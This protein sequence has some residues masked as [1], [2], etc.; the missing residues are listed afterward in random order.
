MSFTV[1]AYDSGARVRLR[2]FLLDRHT[3]NLQARKPHREPLRR[4]LVAAIFLQSS[5]P[6]IRQHACLRVV[7]SIGRGAGTAH[8]LRSELRS[9][10]CDAYQSRGT[11]H[12]GRIGESGAVRIWRADF[13]G[14]DEF[15]FGNEFQR[16]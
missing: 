7:P 4:Q 13:A 14:T 6:S 12:G 16:G 8:E 11:R 1:C 9:C 3:A 15:A 2:S 10:R 5:C